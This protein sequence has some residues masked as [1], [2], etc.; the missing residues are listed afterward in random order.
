[1]GIIITQKSILGFTGHQDNAISGVIMTEEEVIQQGI[2]LLAK[3]VDEDL[4]DYIA[5]VS[6]H[7]ATDGELLEDGVDLDEIILHR[8]M[9][10]EELDRRGCE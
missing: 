10:E 2:E 7:I 8:R 9:C 4:Q 6:F 1:M 3:Y 5:K